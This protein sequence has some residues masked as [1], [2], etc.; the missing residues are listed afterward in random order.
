MLESIAGGLNAMVNNTYAPDGIIESVFGTSQSHWILGVQWHP[1]TGFAGDL[2]SRKIFADFLAHCRA[3][4][5]TD[6]GT[7]T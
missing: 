2:F 3:V 4:R 5:G 6:E 1:E 7:H